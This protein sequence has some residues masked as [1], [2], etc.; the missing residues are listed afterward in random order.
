MGENVRA[1]G[2]A[3][4]QVMGILLTHVHADHAGGARA[5]SEALGA[6][7][8]A[9]EAESVQ[10]AQGTD[11]T[12]GLARAKHSGVYPADYQFPHHRATVVADGWH[13]E[14]DNWRLRAVVAPGHSIGSTSYVLEGASGRDLFSGD[15]V[16]WGGKLGLLNCW[17]SSPEAYR[18]SFGR[19]AELQITGLY[20]GHFLFAVSDGQRHLDDAVEAL[21]G[22]YLPDSF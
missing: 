21:S 15:T 6:E 8:F 11:E 19:L 12:L 9:S 13:V 10:L 2:V 22:V 18:D 3:P 1:L 20:P 16:F 14:T 4:G 17:G 5:L 7:V